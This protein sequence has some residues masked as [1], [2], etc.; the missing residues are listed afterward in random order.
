MPVGIRKGTVITAGYGDAEIT[1]QTATGSRRYTF[2][3][4]L[5]VLDLSTNL[6]STKSLRKKD[7]FYRSDRQYLF[8]KYTDSEDIVIADVYIYNRLLYLVIEPSITTLYSSKVTIKAEAT[9]LV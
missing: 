5:Y 8:M 7:V 4:V 6:L 2:T 3:K 1:I 9:M